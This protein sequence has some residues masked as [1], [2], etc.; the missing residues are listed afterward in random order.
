VALAG[1]DEFALADKL[2]PPATVVAQD[3]AVIGITA[4]LLLFTRINEDTLPPHDVFL[5][6]RFIARG[7][8]EITPPV[9]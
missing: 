2:T 6:T 7:S 3:P 5:L 1:F 4:A 8:G 9:G